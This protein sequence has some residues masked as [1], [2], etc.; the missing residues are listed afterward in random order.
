MQ[1]VSHL[2]IS[3][4]DDEKWMRRA[5]T[6][7]VKSSE[8]GEVPVGAVLVQNGAI[9][10]EG[11]NS[12]ITLHDPTAHAEIIAIRNGAAAASN[13]RLP[14][15]TL[16]VTLEPCIMCVG[17]ILHARIKRLVYGAAD[18][19]TG[20]VS[21]IYNIGSD[22]LLNHSLEITGNILQEQC[23]SLLKLFFKERRNIH[24]NG[25]RTTL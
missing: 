5:L 11:G 4:E 6:I 1:T 3:L 2:N 22:G 17:A 20:A 8:K 23:A 19:K 16:Y 14:G 9:A 25:A 12:S 21:S 24:K 13:Y 15:T 7:A 10:G 18:P